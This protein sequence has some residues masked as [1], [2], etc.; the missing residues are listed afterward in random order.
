MF[1]KNKL[2]IIILIVITSL[3][4]LIGFP[5]FTNIMM[6][7][8]VGI[9]VD[10]S[11]D[12]I[13]FFA[14]YFGAIIGGVISGSLTLFGVKLTIDQQTKMFNRQEE[15]YEEDKYNTAQYIKAEVFHRIINVQTKIKSFNNNN[16]PEN[17]EAVYEASD[18]LDNVVNKLFPQ[19][20][21]TSAELLNALKTVSWAAQDIKEF[22]DKSIK[23]D[24]DEASVVNELLNGRYYQ[25]LALADIMFIDTID[26]F[27][28]QKH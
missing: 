27:K 9:Y 26:S 14:S 2:I 28:L 25:H 12:W 13:G 18:E 4:I 22:I 21:N 23:K 15:K 6:H 11:N 17:I 16:Y 1:S 20:S 5:Y 24:I 7:K 3:L 19:A 8:N 10:D